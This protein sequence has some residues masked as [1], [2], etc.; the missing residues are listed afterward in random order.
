MPNAT[1][2]LTSFTGGEWSPRLQ[3]RVDIQKYNTACEVLENMVLYPHGGITRRMGL[4]YIGDAKN[5]NVRLIPFEYNREQ[6]YV[7]EF[8][9]SYIRF[10]RNGAQIAP[11]GV[12]L[13]VV[14][15]YL[16]DHIKDISFC[17]SNDVLY[18]VHEKYEPRK[19]TR[20]GPDVFSLA[21][22]AFTDT[23]ALPLVKPTSEWTVDNYPCVV[24]LFQSRLVLAGTPNKP[25]KIWMSKASDLENFTLGANANDARAWVL[26]S[27]QNNAIQWAVPSKKLMIGSTGGEFSLALPDNSI[28]IQV[29]RESNFGSKNGRTQ[30]IGSG[31][32]YASRD[33]KKLREMA[34]SFEADGFTSPE[35]SL[36][37]EHLTRP[38][39]KEYDYAQNPDGIL[40]T[41]MDNGSFCGFTYLKSQEVQGWHRHSTDGLVKSVCTIEG[42]TGSEVWFAVYRNG[43]TRVE[44]MAPAFEGDSPDDIACAYLDSYL[45]YEGVPVDNLSGLEHLEGKTVRVLGDGLYLEDKVVIDGEITLEKECSKIIVGLPISWRVIPLRLEGG[46][47]VGF[48]Q[49]KKK[50]VESLIVRLERSAGVNHKIKDGAYQS[51]L[52][53]RKFG[54][55]FDEPI[56]LYSGDMYIKLHSNWSRN[57]QFELSGDSPFPVTILMI[58]ADVVVNE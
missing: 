34:Y 57:G 1:V 23:T 17:Q 49:G 56:T 15:P 21:V 31:V 7:L 19:L 54:D 6:A 27:T 53:V 18:L 11:L 42:D 12:P 8:G 44:K 16:A 22:V 48:S 33:G 26:T 38:G 2:P 4:E 40:W 29:D 41:V 13:E 50:H 24:T 9:E 36:L 52:P 14:S 28:A 45:S 25:Q 30:L 47:P 39:I 5:D 51:E 55:N 32:I 46:S 35:L 37:S 43:A 3:G 20:T 58:G 10:F